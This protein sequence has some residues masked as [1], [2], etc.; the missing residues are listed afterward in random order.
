MPLPSSGPLSTQAVNTEIGVATTTQLSMNQTTVRKLFGVTTPNTTISFSNGYGKSGT[1]SIQ[2]NVIGGGGNGGGDA[3]GGGGGGGHAQKT[4]TI[5]WLTY[6]TAVTVGGVAATSSAFGMT[7]TGGGAGGN[8]FQG[9]SAGGTASGGDYNASGGNGGS[10]ARGGGPTPTAPAT[11]GPITGAGAGA[12]YQDP[13]G[14]NAGSTG[15]APA[16][17]GG[18]SGTSGAAGVAGT[19]YGGGGGGGGNRGGGAGAGA[20]GAVIVK[21]TSATQLFSGGTVTFASG[22]YTHT[23]TSSGTFA[24]T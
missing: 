3:G 23:F 5:S 21:Y 12:G 10:G 14:G 13:S 6:S 11:S 2:A 1:V 7:A 20:T 16:G 8:V 4:L 9:R 18:R 24:N 22:V 15:T 19:I 17:N